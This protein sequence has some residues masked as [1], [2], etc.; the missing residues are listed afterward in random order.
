MVVST[1][2]EAY[3]RTM[4]EEGLNLAKQSDADAQI[5]GNLYTS[6]FMKEEVIFI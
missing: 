5:I 4:I 1:K 2:D 3:T 6:Q